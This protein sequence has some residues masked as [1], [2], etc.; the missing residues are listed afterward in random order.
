[1]D[2]LEATLAILDRLVGSPTIS[3]GAEAGLYSES[4][5][6]AVVCGPGGMARAHEA[7]EWIG[8]EE[9]DGANRM[10]ARLASK[11]DRPIADWMRPA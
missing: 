2:R 9:L 10:M 8:L 3:F 6:P 1:M 5:N 4:S 7:D 11:L